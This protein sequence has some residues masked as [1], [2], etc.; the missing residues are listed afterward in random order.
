VRFLLLCLPGQPAYSAVGEKG[1][2]GTGEE[3]KL[4]NA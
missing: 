1:E 4:K 2:K 3:E